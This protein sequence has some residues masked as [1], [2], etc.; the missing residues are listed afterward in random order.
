M[1]KFLSDLSQ[2]SYIIVSGKGGVGKT[3]FS[4]ALG[5]MLADAGKK[6]LVVSI[7]P[8]HSLGDSLDVG[9]GSKIRTITQNLYCLEFD[10]IDLFASERET[11][12]KVLSPDLG[13]EMGLPPIS[14]E[15]LDLLI[16]TQIP[17]EF[18]EGLGFMKLFYSLMET[19]EYDTVV[20]DTAPTGHTLELLKL[21]EFLDSF[22]GKMIR[23]RLKISKFF[24]KFKALFGL[25]R[26]ESAD[27]TL[28][29]LEE[30]QKH[31]RAVREVLTDP[32]KTEFV[33]VMIPNDMSIFESQRL[34]EEL[35]IH[36]IPH[37]HIV[38]NLVRIYS[39]HCA[40]CKTMSKFHMEQL[41][42]IEKEF[43]GHRIWVIP[44]MSKEIRGIKKLRKLGEIL[45]E[46][47]IEKALELIKS[48]EIIE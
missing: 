18:A 32:T 44:Y 4:A 14:D 36:S 22:Y 20:F 34:V 27:L 3:T 11:L 38:V 30:T 40:F 1:N 41:Q 21:P 6:T 47:D 29:I 43:R 16:N 35:D 48:G 28:K 26:D 46:I 42:K 2:K 23:F 15:M 39:G 8:A 9:I 33:V 45:G 31:I 10:P 13:K 37:T 17:Y 25:G 12:R 5:I 7:D 24:S 19:K